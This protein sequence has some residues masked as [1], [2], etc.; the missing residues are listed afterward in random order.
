MKKKKNCMRNLIQRWFIF[1]GH[2]VNGT[3]GLRLTVVAPFHFFG[4]LKVTHFNVL[5]LWIIHNRQTKNYNLYYDY[6]NGSL[7]LVVESFLFQTKKRK[8]LLNKVRV[9]SMKCVRSF[10]HSFPHFRLLFYTS[11]ISQ[12]D[13]CYLTETQ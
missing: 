5:T 10:H 2:C 6:L 8:I 7:P 4:Y 13:I 11:L 1:K 3:I 9:W 12:R